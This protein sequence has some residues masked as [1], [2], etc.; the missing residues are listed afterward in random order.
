MEFPT[1]AKSRDATAFVNQ[2]PSPQQ[3]PGMT[4]MVISVPVGTEMKIMG[5][6]TKLWNKH[7]AP[8]SR[9]K[10]PQARVT[11]KLHTARMLR[12]AAEL[13]SSKRQSAAL[14]KKAEDLYTEVSGES[15]TDEDVNADV[16]A[17]QTSKE[18]TRL[19]QALDV[20][21]TAQRTVKTAQQVSSKGRTRRRETREEDGIK[22]VEE[23]SKD[24][25]EPPRA[26]TMRPPEPNVRGPARKKREAPPPRHTT[27]MLPD[28][29][30]DLSDFSRFPIGNWIR[31]PPVPHPGSPAAITAP[32]E[33]VRSRPPPREL[34][35]YERYLRRA[36]EAGAQRLE[37]KK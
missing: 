21:L 8:A 2:V 3:S 18:K 36:K 14:L 1:Q 35:E 12:Q 6:V 24:I 27:A 32:P 4:S 31:N 15:S 26:L 5:L 23:V 29:M 22:V 37:R 17:I 7:Y 30:A 25:A 34:S 28:R 10:A 13:T 33:Q 11:E 20:E 9:G 19:K 16:E